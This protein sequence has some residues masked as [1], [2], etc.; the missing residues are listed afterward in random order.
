MAVLKLKK[1]GFTTIKVLFYIKDADIEK[2]LLCNRAEKKF[3]NEPVDYKQ[4][5]KNKITSHGD[6]VTDFLW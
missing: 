1:K 4:S 6:E 5:L 3:D 2:E